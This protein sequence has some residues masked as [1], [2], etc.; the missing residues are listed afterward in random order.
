M[1]DNFPLGK[2]S[3]KIL[4]MGIADSPYIFQQKMNYLFHGFNFIYA[5]M[6]DLLIL[7]KVDCKDHAQNLE[8]TLNKLKGK[9][10]KFNI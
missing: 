10:L 2:I 9:G 4:P 6:D 5:Y 7:T 8:L 3:L 1:Y